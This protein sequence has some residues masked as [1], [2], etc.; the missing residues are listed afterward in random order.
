[1]SWGADS[2]KDV[3][4]WHAVGLAAFV[5]AAVMYSAATGV[6]TLDVQLL[7]GISCGLIAAVVAVGLSR[8]WQHNRQLL[9]FWP[10]AVLVLTI[11]TGAVDVDATRDLPG[12]I[13]LS[14]AY[15][16][17]TLPPGRGWYLL[18]LGLVALIVGGGF[19]LP[20]DLAK[21]V[22]AGIM[23]M[24]VAEVPARLISQLEAQ[25]LELRTAAHTDA[26]TGLLDRTSLA[27][28]LEAHA[29]DASVVLIDLDNFKDFNDTRGHKAGD[30]L[31]VSFAT[32]LRASIRP[33]DLV[34][35]LGGDE[36]LLLLP[37]TTVAEAE[38]VVDRLQT[39]WTDS[40]FAIGF[41]AGVAASGHDALHEADQRMYEQK[42]TRRDVA[43]GSAPVD[44][45]DRG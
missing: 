9:L 20:G 24:L 36:F 5:I 25:K 33:G 4:R 37:V 21:V 11:V 34:F 27:P 38:Q 1:M 40:G 32:A 39:R 23:W 10:A 3:W 7:L 19:G 14:F 16:G 15:V 12:I 17:L 44:G 42:R 31:L 28:E 30:N 35:R 2:A 22:L 13:T 41:S 43:P 29:T 6:D 26:L 18:P 45:E 8:D